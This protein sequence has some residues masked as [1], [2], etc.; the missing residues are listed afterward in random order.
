[1]ATQRHKRRRKAPQK[2]ILIESC[3]AASGMGHVQDMLAH[4]NTALIALKHEVE[5][6]AKALAF[7]QQGIHAQLSRLEVKRFGGFPRTESFPGVTP[8]KEA[9]LPPTA[10]G[11]ER[12]EHDFRPPPHVPEPLKKL[13]CA[14]CG[15]PQS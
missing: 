4:I 3:A 6:D 11:P 5:R 15:A 7:W 10:F 2:R 9:R 12:C 14:H 13:V 8:S 1:M